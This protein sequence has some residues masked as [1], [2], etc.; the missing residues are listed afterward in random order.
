MVRPGSDVFESV[1]FCN[2]GK[3]AVWGLPCNA[4][5]LRHHVAVDGPGGGGCP[6]PS[7]WM[8][9]LPGASQDGGL[10]LRGNPDVA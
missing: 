1:G 8:G 4:A 6:L 9:G 5:T 7:R 2:L 10:L 3:G